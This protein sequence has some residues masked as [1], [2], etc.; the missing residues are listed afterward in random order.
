MVLEASGNLLKLDA[1]SGAQ[2]GSVAVGE[3]PRHVAIDGAGAT[4]YVSRFITPPQPGE[5]TAVVG[6]EVGGVK[7]GGEVLRV[8]A[9]SLTVLDTVYLQHSDKPDA[10]TQGGGVPNY[11]GALVISPD[12]SNAVVPSKQDNIARGTLRSGA[13]LNFQNTV[14]AIASFIDPNL[15]ARGLLA[16]HRFR[17]REP[18]ERSGLRPFRRVWVL[19]ARN[20]PSDRDRR[21]ACR[22]ANCSASTSAR[23]RKVSRFRRT[24]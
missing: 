6:T 22:A 18:D 20:E 14:R 16:A 21:C 5:A 17:Q 23:R 3:H 12:G 9:A 11:L 10:E 13:N 19:R 1:S 24:G 2:L 4:V 15:G 8:N 7:V